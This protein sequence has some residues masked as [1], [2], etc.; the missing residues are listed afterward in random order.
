MFFFQ[1]YFI[2]NLAIGGTSGYFPDEGNLSGKPWRNDSPTP[3]RDFWNGR[4]TWLPTW[5]LH[6]NQG[7]DAAFQVEYVRM[8]SL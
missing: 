5:K 6:S 4:D 2:I 3:I 1:F 8:W 7:R